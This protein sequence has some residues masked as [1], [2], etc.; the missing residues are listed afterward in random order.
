MLIGCVERWVSGCVGECVDR[1][2]WQGMLE[3]VLEEEGGEG[4]LEGVR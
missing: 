4:M 2:C 3:S 1:V